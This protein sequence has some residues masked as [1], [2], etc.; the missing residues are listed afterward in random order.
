MLNPKKAGDRASKS[1]CKTTRHLHDAARRAR[2]WL[3][4]FRPKNGAEKRRCEEGTTPNTSWRSAGRS[5][6]IASASSPIRSATRPCDWVQILMALEKHYRRASDRRVVHD[7]RKGFYT[8]AR[9]KT[10]ASPDLRL[11]HSAAATRQRQGQGGHRRP[12]RS[13]TPG[14]TRLH[15]RRAARLPGKAA[16]A[17]GRPSCPNDSPIGTRS[18]RPQKKSRACEGPD[19]RRLHRDLP[20]RRGTAASPGTRRPRNTRKKTLPTVSRRSGVANSSGAT[21]PVKDDV[22]VTP[23]DI[24]ARAT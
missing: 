22:D 7:R 14:P 4:S 15:W 8:L 5:T 9:P 21:L 2:P 20:V 24:A 3:T 10:S 16:T 19:R 13:L 23:E 17:N 11:S 6:G 18:C 1:G 12:A